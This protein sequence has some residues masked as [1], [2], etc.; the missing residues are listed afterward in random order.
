MP[1]LVRIF[2]FLAAA[3]LV[4]SAGIATEAGKGRSRVYNLPEGDASETLRSFATLSGEQVLYL[5]ESVRGER[6]QA[7]IGRFSARDALAHMLVGTALILSE[8]PST[9]AFFVGRR[10]P[11]PTLP[12]SP[13]QRRPRPVRPAPH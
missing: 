9:G 8:D 4:C 6:T 2:R 5:V 10:R 12:T 3:A 13:G 7:V 1:S 11:P